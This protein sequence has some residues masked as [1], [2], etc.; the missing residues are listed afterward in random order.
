M[1]PKSI[2]GYVLLACGIL[3]IG[4]ALVSSR[5][6]FSGNEEPPA[7]FKES[8]E[9]KNDTDSLTAEQQIEGLLE[10]QFEKLIPPDAIIKAL[11]LFSWSVFAGLL[12]F[13]GVQ[14]GNLGIKLLRIPKKEDVI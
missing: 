14:I 6:I 12:V 11:N 1:S 8:I 7:V 9:Q 5:A 3:I 4:Y 2:I 10:K 13:G